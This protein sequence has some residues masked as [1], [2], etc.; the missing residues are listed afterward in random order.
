ME[1]WKMKDRIKKY[2]DNLFS[3][4][5]DTRQL[6][7]LKEEIGANL[8]EKVNDFVAGGADEETAFKNA[9]ASLGDMSEL[10][11]GL[12]KASQTKANEDTFKTFPLDKKHALAYVIASAIFLFGVM[13]SGVIY[14]RQSEMLAALVSLMPF[15]L[16][17]APIF[18][19]FGLTQETSQHY[20]MDSKRAVLY[21]A[22]GEIFLLGAMA[23]GTL[24]F[25]GREFFMVFAAL[26]P[27][28]IV[29]S[30][31]F[32]YLG[33]T[34]KSRL[35]MSPEWVKQW[36]EYYSNPH[37]M[38]LR[39]AISGALWIFSIAAFFLVAFIWGWKLS[40]IVFVIA[41][42]LQVLF[43]AFF[44]TKSKGN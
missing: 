41:I 6:R 25:R 11:T 5:Y 29:S 13:V 8:L 44:A 21:T 19:Y 30:A 10:V 20:G 28:V 7:E 9:V 43:E 33:L 27:F 26:M 12:K 23:A 42:G 37:V 32:I 14:L 31:V 4:I 1:V 3:D 16:V 38:M 17:S 22:A 40:W 39:G 15:I 2:I 35:K 34:E 36:V 18:G 24:Y